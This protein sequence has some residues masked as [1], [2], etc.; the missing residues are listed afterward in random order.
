ML[1]P[2]GEQAGK[3][4][5]SLPK[6]LYFPIQIGRNLHENLFRTKYQP[7]SCDKLH[8]LL[9]SIGWS[10]RESPK[11]DSTICNSLLILA[12]HINMLI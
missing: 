2:G 10:P 12:E 11:G 4:H 5:F 7:L 6:P 3:S 9:A 1:T 8:N